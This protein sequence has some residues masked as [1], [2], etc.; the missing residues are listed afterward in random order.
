M[1]KVVPDDFL[2][3]ILSF[4]IGTVC[5]AQIMLVQLANNSTTYVSPRLACIERVKANLMT[6]R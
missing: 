4:E 5:L 3:D 6:P 1:R 2:W